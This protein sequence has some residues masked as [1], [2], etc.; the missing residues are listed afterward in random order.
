MKTIV[1]GILLGLVFFAVAKQQPLQ[2]VKHVD[3]K[4]YMGKWNE[5]AGIPQHFQK[6]CNCTE[7]N[8]SLSENGSIKVVN[9]CIKDGKLKTATGKARIK[10][11]E[12]NARLSVRFSWPF[13]GKYWIIELADDYSYS[14]VAH[15]NRKYLWILSRNKTMDDKTYKA[16]VERCKAKGFDVSLLKRTYQLCEAS[17]AK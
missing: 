11:K 6:G 9:K 8:Y 13:S 7:A 2:T 15:P 4:K 12:S 17:E 10:D 5:I 16:I 3:V 1:T 14:V